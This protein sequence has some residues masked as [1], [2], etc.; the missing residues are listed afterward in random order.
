MKEG[1]IS[2]RVETWFSANSG[3]L[4][5]FHMVFDSKLDERIFSF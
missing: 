3:D 4:N 2:S 5:G 1:E